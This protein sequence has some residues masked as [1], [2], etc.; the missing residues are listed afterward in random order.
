MASPKFALAPKAVEDPV[1]PSA[2]AISVER[3]LSSA[4]VIFPPDIDTL[5]EF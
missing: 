3:P 1:P 4:P 2:I 5:L